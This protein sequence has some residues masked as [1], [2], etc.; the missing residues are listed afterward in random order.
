MP[1][2]T[3][4]LKRELD[5]GLERRVQSEATGPQPEKA[6]LVAD[7]SILRPGIPLHEF[8]NALSAQDFRLVVPKGLQELFTNSDIPRDQLIGLLEEYGIQGNEEFL[9]TKRAELLAVDP[10][11]LYSV[12][13]ADRESIYSS[14]LR[15]RIRLLIR[16]EFDWLGDTAGDLLTQFVLEVIHAGE[17]GIRVGDEVR[18]FALLLFGKGKRLANRTLEILGRAGRKIVRVTEDSV[19]QLTDFFRRWSARK[20]RFVKKHPEFLV[21]MTLDG[22]FLAVGV[23]FVGPHTVHFALHF[24][25]DVIVFVYNGIPKSVETLPNPPG[26]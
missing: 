26:F 2:V 5:A 8:T 15:E 3:P 4:Q 18:R 10:D 21:E 23:F 24:G 20:S 9:Q 22:L 25:K 19:G 6:R 12:P 11:T 1:D 17:V 16:D 14:P 13:T 7:L